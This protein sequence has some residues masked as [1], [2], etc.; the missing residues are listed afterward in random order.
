MSQMVLDKI[1]SLRPKNSDI[2]QLT[3]PYNFPDNF[4]EII[5]CI[6]HDSDKS[7]LCGAA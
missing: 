5:H 2:L 1:L 6:K 4:V 7:Q 3:Y